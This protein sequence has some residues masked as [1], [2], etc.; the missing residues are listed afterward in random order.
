MNVLA[1][2]D[3]REVILVGHSYA[4]MVITGVAERVPERL[5]HL[6]YLDAF[7]PEDGESARAIL[8]RVL[9]PTVATA[10]DEQVRAM[11]RVGVFLVPQPIRTAHRLH[12]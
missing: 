8:A 4:G 5:R 9:G 1:Y 7:V 11:A 6:V 3:V 10:L 2:E 12:A